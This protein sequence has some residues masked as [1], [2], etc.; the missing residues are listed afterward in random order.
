MS[1]KVLLGLGAVVVVGATAFVCSKVKKNKKGESSTEEKETTENQE[2]EVVEVVEE[3]VETETEVEVTDEVEEE[4]CEECKAIKDLFRQDIIPEI[5]D[6]FLLATELEQEDL[7]PID[8]EFGQIDDLYY[9]GA[10]DPVI[11]EQKLSEL[12]DKMNKMI[13]E[14]KGKESDD[15]GEQTKEEQPTE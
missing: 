5:H 8:N 4:D 10:L 2:E 15:N 3:E 7:E 13:E 1:K 6:I 14:N 9:K 11:Y 12:I